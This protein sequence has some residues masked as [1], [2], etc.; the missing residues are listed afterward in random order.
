MALQS[1]EHN[2]LIEPPSPKEQCDRDQTPEASHPRHHEKGQHEAMRPKTCVSRG[3]FV[4]N[5]PNNSHREHV[6]TNGTCYGNGVENSSH[7]PNP[8][9]L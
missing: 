1:L 9:Y 6:R 2:Q 7:V 8:K 3:L 5:I 4:I